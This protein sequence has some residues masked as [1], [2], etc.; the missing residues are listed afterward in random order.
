MVSW[1]PLLGTVAGVVSGGSK[2]GAPLFL[3]QTAA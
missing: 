3:D 1:H 2:G